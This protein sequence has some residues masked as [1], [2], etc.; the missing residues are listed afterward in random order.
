MHASD[1]N[2]S[3]RQL[4]A[5]EWGEGYS[6]RHTLAR[7][8]RWMD[9]ARFSSIALVCIYPLFI[10][11][12][13]M[14][15]TVL[16]RLELPSRVRLSSLGRLLAEP[17][18]VF[19]ARSY[20][21]RAAALLHDSFGAEDLGAAD[22]LLGLAGVYRQQERYAE[23]ERLYDRAL[24]ILMHHLGADSQRVAETLERLA[25]F[26]L[27]QGKLA[28]ASAVLEFARSLETRHGGA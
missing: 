4:S 25:E 5:A 22:G 9:D 19:E 1:S 11:G 24:V 8:R 23:A 18:P 7:L 2:A 12:I 15:M 26:Y 21:R 3:K 14:V 17:D 20:H 10:L 27:A 13:V 16:A 28:M 6:L